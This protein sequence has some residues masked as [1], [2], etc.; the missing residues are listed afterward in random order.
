M[1]VARPIA[2]SQDF[3]LPSAQLNP[4]THRVPILSSLEFPMEVCPAQRQLNDISEFPSPFSRLREAK[5]WD[6]KRHKSWAS[7]DTQ[8]TRFPY[9]PSGWVLTGN[10]KPSEPSYQLPHVSRAGWSLGS[11]KLPPTLACI[12]SSALPFISR[13]SHAPGETAAATFAKHG[14]MWS[15][16]HPT[17]RV[18]WSLTLL[19][20]FP[21]L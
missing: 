4:F 14:A 11:A 6:R 16:S 19:N 18:T 2:M 21:H 8:M 3:F 7:V 1:Q 5:H 9:R 17:Q 15:L 10:F 20:L 12:G 13:E